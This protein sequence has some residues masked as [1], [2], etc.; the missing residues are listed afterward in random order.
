MKISHILAASALSLALVAPA[1]AQDAATPADEH[2]AM[3][4]KES[5]MAKAS[6]KPRNK[7]AHHRKAA[8]HAKMAAMDHEK[9][10]DKAMSSS[11]PK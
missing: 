5:S 7:A 8:H 3:A 2:T 9:A 4:A 6:T 11:E 1:F 10:A